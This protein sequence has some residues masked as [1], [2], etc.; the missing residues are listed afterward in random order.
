MYLGGGI[1]Y[2]S[3]LPATSKEKSSTSRV[4]YTDFASQ[5]KERVQEHGHKQKDLH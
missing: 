2:D 1:W 5:Q 3:G 4:S